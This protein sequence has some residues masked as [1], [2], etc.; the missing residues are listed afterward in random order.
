VTTPT[1][2]IITGTGA[3]NLIASG[4]GYHA[5]DGGGGI[6]T[7]VYQ[8]AHTG[9]A[10]SI[11]AASVTVSGA[12]LQDTLVSVER[13]QFSDASVAFDVNGNAGAAYRLYQA[14]FDRAPEAAG[15]GYWIS[16]L[17]SGQASLD[18]VSAGFAS[19]KEFADLYGANASDSQFVQ[20]LY[21]NVLHR[22]AEADGYAFWLDAIEEHGVARADVL[23]HFS[24][25]VENQVQVVANIQDGMLFIPWA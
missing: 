23:S 18:Q 19:S 3:G 2:E 25:S 20:Q 10:V 15:R 14:A 22:P 16:M 12:G 7:V 4:S 8:G 21:Q 13:L 11:G 9:Y 6:D 17:D 24:E 5:I 1:P